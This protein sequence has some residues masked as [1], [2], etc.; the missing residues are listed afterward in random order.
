M[1][2]QTTTPSSPHQ[3]HQQLQKSLTMT[4]AYPQNSASKT[5]RYKD[6]SVNE[7]SDDEIIT[8]DRGNNPFAL[9]KEEAQGPR[10]SSQALFKGAGYIG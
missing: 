2:H 1:V 3:Q 6:L 5:S 10:R 4:R 9:K 7:E 8:I